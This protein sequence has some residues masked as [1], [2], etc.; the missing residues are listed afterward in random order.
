MREAAFRERVVAV[1]IQ[2]MPAN[3]DEKASKLQDSGLNSTLHT[4]YWVPADLISY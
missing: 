3:Q 4:P 1:I 2:G